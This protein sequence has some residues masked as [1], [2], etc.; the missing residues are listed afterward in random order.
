MFKGTVMINN[1]QSFQGVAKTNSVNKAQ[2]I[3]NFKPEE[4]PCDKFER[5]D[6][7]YDV[8]SKEQKQKTVAKA[9]I[10]ASGWSALAGATASAYY[11]LRSDETVAKKYNLD[12]KK[13]KDLIRTIKFE[14][15]KSTIPAAIGCSF[16]GLGQLLFGGIAY[17][18]NKNADPGKIDV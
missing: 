5:N 13:D 7:S 4:I 14:Q 11:A 1:V 9:K 6:C 16:Y 12:V 8:L 3:P 17:I 18:Y 10:T 15:V 2:E